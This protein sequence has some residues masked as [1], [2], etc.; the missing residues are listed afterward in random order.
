MTKVKELRSAAQAI[1]VEARA[2]LETIT[3]D[4]SA[5]TAASVELRY[6]AMMADRENKVAQATRFEQ[7]DAAIAAD[8]AR[9]DAE[10]RAAHA[11]R[12]HSPAS[13]TPESAAPRD[14]HR[15]AF[16][17][18][19]QAGGDFSEM[20]TEARAA[21][22]GLTQEFRTQTTGPTSAGVL[23]PTTLAA[24]INIAM[25]LHGPMYDGDVVTEISLAN[26]AP[27]DLPQVD[28]TDSE[29]A[30]ASE[31][32]VPAD[33]DSADLTINKAS[34]GAFDFITPWIKWSLALSMDSGFGYEAL[35]SKIIGEQLGRKANRALTT[36]TGSGQP[37]G[38]V[39][40]SLLGVTAA[41]ATLI[42][43]DNIK[44]LIHSVDPAYRSAPKAR[45]MMHDN[46]VKAL[47]KIKDSNGVFIWQYGDVSKGVPATLEGKPVSINQAMAGAEAA[48]KPIIFGD[49]AEYYTRKA[50]A[51]LIGVAREKFFPNTGLAGVI[52]LDGAVGTAKAIRHLA[53]AA[54]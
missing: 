35:L 21:L 23:V 26:G 14:E 19:L 4:M 18:M 13:F 15:E 3:P 5:E 42:T 2:L 24:S 9:A 28:D 17:A 29:A 22:R 43:F 11:R 36:G 39:N 31:G 47:S 37:L 54:G 50:G 38:V 48:S 30:A 7:S 44:D 40:G 8:E 6:D 16:K 49:M 45:F 46:S 53:M 32:A 12:P 10:A 1:T 20:S 52:R 41:S 27:F 25:A 34:L 51:P 33:D